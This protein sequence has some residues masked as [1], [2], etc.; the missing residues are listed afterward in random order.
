MTTNQ[1]SN[2]G[3]TQIFEARLAA[4]LAIQEMMSEFN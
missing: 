1:E 3:Q 4:E 2:N